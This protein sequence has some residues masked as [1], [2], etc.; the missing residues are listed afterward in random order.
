MSCLKYK[1]CRNIEISLAISKSNKVE[2]TQKKDLS[3]MWD[4]LMNFKVQ[5]RILEKTFCQ[6]YHFHIALY[7]V[8]VLTQLHKGSVNVHQVIREG[9]KLCIEKLAV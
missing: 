9:F 3:S 8:A 4:P 6:K 2:V 7:W 5:I 1:P